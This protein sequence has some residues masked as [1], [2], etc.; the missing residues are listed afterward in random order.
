MKC[1]FVVDLLFGDSGKA[2]VTYS[3]LQNSKYT[4]CMR[5]N[6]GNNAGGTVIYN[7]EKFVLNSVPAGVF[8]GV[9]SLVGPE[10]VLNPKEF[11]NELDKFESKGI[12]AK[13]LVKVAYNTH[14]ITQAHIDE[15]INENKIGSTRRGIGPA[16]RDKYARVG[17]Q[18]KDISE[19]QPY[20]IDFHE[21]IFDQSKEETIILYEGAQG[22]YLDIS[23]EDYPY[24]TS[25]HCTVAGALLN[26]IPHL[27]IRHVYGLIK[28]YETYVGLKDFEPKDPIFDKIRQVGREIG[29]NTGR[30]RSL[31]F[32]NIDRIKKAIKVNGVSHLVINKMDVLQEVNCWKVR[33]NDGAV[34][35][36]QTEDNFKYYLQEKFKIVPNIIFSYSPERI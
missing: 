24:V 14:I 32:L 8:T 4:H 5:G 3:L 7:G 16:Y 2:K 28:A 35:D 10:C 17:I 19:L 34:I 6:G 12:P 18:A 11:L 33:Y 22:F 29:S 13:S 15:E 25:S 26:G 27:A 36:L 21:E 23:S 9:R 20:L 31:N 1:D 30:P